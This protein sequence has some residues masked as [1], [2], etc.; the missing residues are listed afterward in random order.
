MYMKK[1]II[2]N[3]KMNY[4]P[5]KAGAWIRAFR[6]E[7]LPK[8]VDIAVAVPFVSLPAA[9]ASLGRA[10]IPA[11][12]AQD[13][14]W[15]EEGAYTGEI[16][17]SM[18]HEFG[19]EMCL[20]GHSERR[21]FCGE[22]DDM[23]AKKAGSL[24]A[25]NIVPVICVGDTAVQR[26]KGEHMKVV[27]AQV[28]AAIAM[29]KADTKIPFVIAYEPV[30]AIG[31]GKPCVPQDARDMHVA[32]RGVLAKKFGATTSEK[33]R[34][35]YGGSVDTRNILEYMT[36]M[37]IDGALVGGAS[38]DPRNFGLLCRAAVPA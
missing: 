21:A 2:S 30:W 3:W 16:S 4:G 5:I 10:S 29:L 14:F 13:C 20:V 1:L 15:A 12:S 24:Q 23:I 11:L 27:K 9:R 34:I 32:I 31:S 37:G 6:R 26:K 18:L 33:I 22:T 38:L 28:A 7:R 35:I 19:T 25:H 8:D 36:T 17:A